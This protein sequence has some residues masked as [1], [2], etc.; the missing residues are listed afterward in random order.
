[1]NH[2]ITHRMNHYY[3][4]NLNLF[5]PTSEWV[6][7]HAPR[8]TWSD[9]VQLRAPARSNSPVAST[10][11]LLSMQC[12]G[13]TA[14]GNGWWHPLKIDITWGDQRNMGIRKSLTSNL[15]D[16][17]IV[18]KEHV[19]TINLIVLW[20]QGKTWKTILSYQTVHGWHPKHWFDDQHVSFFGSLGSWILKNLEIFNIFDD[21]HLWLTMATRS[22]MVTDG[23]WWLIMVNDG[24][25]HV[26][27]L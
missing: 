16:L 8:P 23:S 2:R 17:L 11:R 15:I 3:R 12:A 10:P 24:I 7:T 9:S 1:M 18:R 14:G 22:I 27:I 25:F 6:L 20:F 13:P 4:Y 26:N 19:L 5:F 21:Q